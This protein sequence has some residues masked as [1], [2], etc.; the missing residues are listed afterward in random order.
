MPTIKATTT[1]DIRKNFKQYADDVADYDD[2]VIVTRPDNKNVVMISEAEYN[3]WQETN[4][5]LKT[6]A[7][8]KAI[9]ESLSQLDDNNSKVLTPEDWAKMVSQHE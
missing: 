8:R 4:Y 9:R 6:D 3:S 5:L 7:N 2:A 1:R